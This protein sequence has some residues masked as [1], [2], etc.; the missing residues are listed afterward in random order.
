MSVVSI[1]SSASQEPAMVRRSSRTLPQKLDQILGRHVNHVR[2]R[3]NDEKRM[4]LNPNV[5]Q[6]LDAIIPLS[7]LS[8]P[9]DTTPH[10]LNMTPVEL[11][12]S[13]FPH[14]PQ[15]L[16]KAR[17]RS[18]NISSEKHNMPLHELDDE[19]RNVVLF[20]AFSYVRQNLESKILK[21]RRIFKVIKKYVHGRIDEEHLKTTV[22][23]IMEET[24]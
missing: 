7:P 3:G 8:F 19:L 15:R 1:V 4:M 21:R 24:E 11:I 17:L 14:V 13:R 22:H 6:C 16:V 9:K 12:Q 18:V 23:G 20:A 2:T 5:N 10:E